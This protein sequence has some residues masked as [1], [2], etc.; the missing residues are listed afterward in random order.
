RSHARLLLPPLARRNLQRRF[1]GP[2]NAPPEQVR[3]HGGE[4]LLALVDCHA[5]LLYD[6]CKH[7]VGGVEGVR[8]IR[9]EV[10]T[11]R[12]GEEGLASLQ[13]SSSCLRVFGLKSEE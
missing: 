6:A 3:G 12:N 11:R 9:F 7:G 1:P 5:D 4:N 2:Q 10:R 8:A 13:P